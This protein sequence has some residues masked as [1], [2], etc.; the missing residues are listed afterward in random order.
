MS[1]KARV[2][3]ATNK[4]NAGIGVQSTMR[5]TKDENGEEISYEFTAFPHARAKPCSGIAILPVE[6]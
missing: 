4:R 2:T 5:K 1:G 3:T 6:V